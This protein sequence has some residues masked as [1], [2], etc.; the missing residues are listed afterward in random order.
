MSRSTHDL[1]R[2][3]LSLLLLK[4]SNRSDKSGLSCMLQSHHECV[5]MVHS[6]P[7]APDLETIPYTVIKRTSDYE[8]RE[9]EVWLPSS[10]RKERK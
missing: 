7:A 10:S 1:S 6:Y 5:I 2:A 9:V 4:D 3:L 8:V